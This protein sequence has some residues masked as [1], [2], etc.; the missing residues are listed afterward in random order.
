MEMPGH[1]SKLQHMR[2][3]IPQGQCYDQEYVNQF[4]QP[5]VP[6][7]KE[8]LYFVCNCAGRKCYISHA[9]TPEHIQCC[10]KEHPANENHANS[11]LPAIVVS[12]PAANYNMQPS[13]DAVQYAFVFNDLHFVG[14]SE[15]HAHHDI[16]YLRPHY[17]IPR[18]SKLKPQATATASASSINVL[19]PYHTPLVRPMPSSK[20]YLAA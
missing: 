19:A 6:F 17:S 10:I 18:R 8:L 4:W 12:A 16:C 11:C 7:K 15:R 9:Q 20:G 2:K 3:D 1:E 14:I 13:I 5:P